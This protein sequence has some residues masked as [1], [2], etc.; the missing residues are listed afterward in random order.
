[1][2]RIPLHSLIIMVG[3]TGGGKSTIA[4]K[5]FAEYEIVSSDSIRYELTGDLLRQDTNDVVFREI[6]RRVALKLDIGE[7]AVV[8]ST[9]LRKRDRLGLVDIALRHGVPV[10]Y[11]VANRDL[12]LKEAA[13]NAGE[14]SIG[15]IRK[16]HDIFQSNERDILHGDSIANVIDARNEEFAVIS[17]LPKTNILA[18][19]RN[20]G[21]R[22]VM[23]LGDV[24]GMSAG[25]KDATDWATQRGLF[26]VFLGDVVDYGPNSLECVEHIYDVIMRGR[27]LMVMGNHERKIERW[28]EQSRQGEIR[29]RLSE[30]NK[31]TTKA[32]ESLSPDSRRK[33][34]CKFKALVGFS[35]H[36][37]IIGNT[38]FA[39]GAAEPEMFNLNSSRLSGR[40]ETMAL[41]GEVD[42]DIKTREDGYPN[43]VY[44]WVD[45]IPAGKNVM[46]GHDIRS[47]YKPL[48]VTNDNGGSAYFMDTGSG[49]GGRLTSADAMFEGDNLSVKAFKHH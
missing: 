18:T 17:K 9:N 22:G 39:H 46:V 25:L 30:G 23:V 15:T 38:L 42:N 33:F 20:R 49:K 29:L 12:H 27:G 8:D 32:I 4:A 37:W 24:H 10:F 19:L 16:Q 43:R 5:K 1:M 11:I 3:P 48:I 13:V 31:A 44:R 2:K 6:N 47:T 26:S 40:F 14:G 34:E 36:H 45:R 35:R 21:Y 7:R 28:I 41:F